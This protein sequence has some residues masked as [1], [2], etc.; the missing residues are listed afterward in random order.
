MVSPFADSRVDFCHKLWNVVMQLISL[1]SN[2]VA[3][4]LGVLFLEHSPNLTHLCNTNFPQFCH[5]YLGNFFELY[6]SN[7]A[8]RVH[9][10][11]IWKK[12]VFRIYC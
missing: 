4:S 6:T 10:T 1:H 8:S 2:T 7:T 5:V 12:K 9:H 3:L 11:C